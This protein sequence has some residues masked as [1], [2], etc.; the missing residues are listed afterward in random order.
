NIAQETL[1]DVPAPQ[2]RVVNMNHLGRALTTYDDPPV[3][4]L[5][6]YNSNPLATS[7]DQ[8]E[9]RRGLMRD[10]L[11]T[12]VHDQVMTDTAVYADLVLP[13]TTLLEHYDVAR[14][15]GT[16]QRPITRPVTAPAGPSRP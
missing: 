3:S 9:I 2:T 16:Y 15:P 12:V 4:V 5:F 1:V 10:D 7:P 8:N 13:A 11:F 14:G 6:V